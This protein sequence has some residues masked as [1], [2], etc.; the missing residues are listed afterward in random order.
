MV[1]DICDSHMHLRI[2][3]VCMFDE[4]FCFVNDSLQFIAFEMQKDKYQFTFTH[5]VDKSSP[6]PCFMTMS[7]PN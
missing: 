3:A 4:D 6:V 5:N 1:Y 7:I 2:Y